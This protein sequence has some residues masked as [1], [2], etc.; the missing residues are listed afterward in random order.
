MLCDCYQLSLD[1]IY[2]GRREGLPLQIAQRIP[3]SAE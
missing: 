1:W 2:L 3:R